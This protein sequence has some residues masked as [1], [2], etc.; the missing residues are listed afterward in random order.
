MSRK[1]LIAANWKMHSAPQG[2][3]AEDSPYRNHG[4]CDIVVFPTALDLARCRDA[5]LVTG[6]QAGRPEQSGAF[7]GDLSITM[8]KEAGC[9]YVLCGHSERR[10][11]HGE[12]DAFVIEQVIA[13]IEAGMH[14]ILCVGETKEEHDAGKTKEVLKRQIGMIHTMITPNLVLA[15]EPMWAIGSGVSATPEKAQ[16]I[17]AYLRGLLAESTRTE[18]RILYG[19]SVDEKNA[20]ALLAQEDVDGF[21]VGGC[22]LEPRTF[23]SI[24]EI[25]RAN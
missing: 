22:S 13:A 17:H 2:F 1:H 4:D 20:A 16:E 23:A 12:S 21:I 18:T 15:Y 11:H 8:L 19:G 7:T 9:R 14:P 5:E 10:R 6:A 25:A 3:D 24:V